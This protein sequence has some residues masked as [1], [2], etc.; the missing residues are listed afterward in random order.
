MSKYERVYADLR[1]RLASGEFK[2]GDDFPSIATV[3]RKHEVSMGTA[4]R[5]LGKLRAEGL[6]LIRQGHQ[7]QVVALP[8]KDELDVLAE[9]QT[10][11]ATLNRLIDH[12]SDSTT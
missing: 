9:L 3:M 4:E 12:L 2:P 5:A 10:I 7:N 8:P 11:R 1:E 6:I